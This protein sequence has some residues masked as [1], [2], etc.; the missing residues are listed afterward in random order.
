MVER[1][2]EMAGAMLEDVQHLAAVSHRPDVEKKMA[3]CSPDDVLARVYYYRVH[4]YVEQIALV[5]CLEEFLESHRDVSC[6]FLC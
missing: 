5:N 6:F 2:L 3:L 4:D 1:A